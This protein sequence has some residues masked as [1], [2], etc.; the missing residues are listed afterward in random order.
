M[1]PIEL[2]S[3]DL[4]EKIRLPFSNL[5]MGD[6]NGN[7]TISPSESRFFDFDFVVDGNKLG[8][9]SISIN[10]PGTCKIFYGRGILDNQS[11]EIQKKWYQ[12]LKS[13]RMFCKR[14]LLTFDTRDITRKLSKDDFKFLAASGSNENTVSESK[15]Y[16]S[17]KTSYHPLGSTLL[18]VKHSKPIDQEY[19]GAR[20]RNITSIMIQND[21]GERFK[22]P[23]N[24][25]AG[26]RA[27]QRHVANQGNPYDDKGQDILYM[28]ETVSKLS[29][30]KRKV[31]IHDS[32]PSQSKEI[33]EVVESKIKSLRETIK[34]LCSQRF[35]E[36][37][38]N[39]FHEKTKKVIVDEVTAQ[40][41]KEALTRP[42]F[43]QELTEYFPL[44]HSIMQEANQINLDEYLENVQESAPLDLSPKPSSIQEIDQFE[45][46]AEQLTEMN[47]SD[48]T[49]R[50]LKKLISSNIKID[51]DGIN[52]IQSLRNIGIEDE[53]LERLIKNAGSNSDL[54]TVIKI[55]LTQNG[56]DDLIRELEID[57]ETEEESESSDQ[58][59]LPEPNL[60][61]ENTSSSKEELP[62]PNLDQ[63]NT[64]SSKE[65]LP[66][67]NLDKMMEDI[68]RLSGLKK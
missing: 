65:E 31:G 44:I 2:I 27:M 7:V 68:L 63:E 15:M 33:M 43:S 60:D 4:F 46:W 1:Q 20:S 18:I 28:C 58:E 37:W 10:E 52:P 12:F 39:G 14:R 35:Y 21:D 17:K 29:K 34:R 49:I 54:N 51:L 11:Q 41:Y 45:E 38:A 48:S 55:W 25:L 32:M 24:Y 53:D 26:A 16:G 66:E 8:R 59:E 3:Q 40:F 13:M 5:E 47:M 57:S 64:S 9:V 36:T 42:S 50:D 19:V 62:E 23:Y 30:F 61:Q 22:F 67:P 56:Q 6:E